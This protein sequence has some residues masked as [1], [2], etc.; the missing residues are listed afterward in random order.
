M[1]YMAVGDTLI[2]PMHESTEA[3]HF[4]QGSRV[5]V[6]GEDSHF[7]VQTR[8][9][10]LHNACCVHLCGCVVGGCAQH[11]LRVDAATGAGLRHQYPHPK[12]VGQAEKTLGEWPCSVPW[13]G[14]RERCVHM[15]YGMEVECQ[16]NWPRRAY[17]VPT[18]VILRLTNS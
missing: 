6:F 2:L 10:I 1:Q 8:S 13:L 7:E 5:S 16:T 9:Q 15:V 17:I 3:S 14:V 11:L 18:E 4:V 12:G